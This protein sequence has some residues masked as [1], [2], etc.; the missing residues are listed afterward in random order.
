M[1]LR[2]LMPG[3][4]FVFAFPANFFN[5]NFMSKKAFCPLVLPLFLAISAQVF[6]QNFVAPKFE[7]DTLKDAEIQQVV[8]TAQF[9]PTDSRQTVNSVRVID[10]KTI[11]QRGAVNLE[12]LLQ[13]EPGL[14]IKQD[15]ILGSSLSINGL[16]GQNVKILV[17]GVP[18]IGRLNGSV[19]AAQLPLGAVRQV[20]IIEGA[21]SL[22]YGSEASAGVINLITKNSQ[23]PKIEA[24]ANFLHETNGFSTKQA[25]V[26][27]R[28]GKF[29]LSANAG[30]TDFSP[31]PDS[32]E[33]N[34]VWNPKNQKFA[35]AALR[36]SPS[37]KLDLR[38][39]GNLFHEKITN[40]GEIRRPTYKPYSFD[41]YYFTDRGDVSLHAEGKFSQF[42]WQTTAAYN[43]FDRVKNGYRLDLENAEKTL[44]PEAQDT[45]AAQGFLW[46]STFASQKNRPLN[47]LAGFEHFTET[48]RDRRISD[49]TRTESGFA[50]NRDLGVFSSLKWT[51]S[52]K[53][54]LQT[55]ARLTLNQRFGSAFSPSAWL[56]WSPAKNLT[57][58][59]SYANG[60]RSPGLKELYFQFIDVNHFVVGNPDLKPE[61]SHNFRLEIARPFFEKNRFSTTATVHGFFN[62]I[63]DRI[64]LTQ[65]G[66]VEYV[67]LNIEKWQTTGA[68]FSLNLN[69]YDRVKWNSAVV[70]TG[71]Y[72]TFLSEDASLRPM[73]WSPDWTND[74]TFSFL[75]NRAS[76]N[77]WHKTT[78]STPFF[79]L[80]DGKTYEGKIKAWHLL[81]GSVGGNFFQKKIRL[82]GG[83]KNILDTRQIEAGATDG[84]GHQ[85][86]GFQ[87]PAH[88]GRT[89]F[90][91]GIFA[92][93]FGK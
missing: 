10:K 58:K 78:G 34:Q 46:R 33:R 68:G 47:W 1:A 27:A 91:Q 16:Q 93:G 45:S 70:L 83:V 89:F 60:F 42:F 48:A 31:A 63:N 6:S 73:L 62:K 8:V 7:V 49:S 84:V 67:Y 88:W 25:R 69:W 87:Q 50:I 59:A 82:T 22:M 90:V 92:L 52:P 53:I 4:L 9:A 17:D 20:E 30:L 79:F 28:L 26:G 3:V 5:S 65:T 55:G 81:N 12:E 23:A 85:N 54:I 43:R 29:F 21:Q 15:A 40:L 86:A 80:E 72:N 64:A 57:V 13:N 14:R 56:R 2:V 41:D 24:E 51:V 44:L 71:F 38:L 19:D 61:H 76:L 18:V 11:E 66:Q 36:F 74:L 35:R 39:T 37:E 75:K 32:T 77:F